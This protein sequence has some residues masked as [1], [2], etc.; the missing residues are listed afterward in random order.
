MLSG[1]LLSSFLK[2]TQEPLSGNLP[3]L[4]FQVL[5]SNTPR[6]ALGTFSCANRFVLISISMS[7][8][9]IGFIQ[10]REVLQVKLNYLYDFNFFISSGVASFKLTAAPPPLANATFKIVLSVT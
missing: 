4:K 6:S 2:K 8:I 7:R 9:F 10:G 5:A 1:I 3:S